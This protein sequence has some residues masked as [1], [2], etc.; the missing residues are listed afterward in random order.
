MRPCSDERSRL[1]RF[2]RAYVHEQRAKVGGQLARSWIE[3]FGNRG[4]DDLQLCIDRGADWQL[5]RRAQKVCN[6]V[7]MDLAWQFPQ[8]VVKWVNLCRT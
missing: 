2:G 6:L 8:Q 5:V 1:R 7:S 4:V 3:Q